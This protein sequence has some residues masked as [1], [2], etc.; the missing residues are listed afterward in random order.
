MENE[1]GVVERKAGLTQSRETTLEL[2][3]ALFLGK[4]RDKEALRVD[5]DGARGPEGMTWHIMLRACMHV[6]LK[7]NSIGWG[8]L[9]RYPIV[10]E[11]VLRTEKMQHDREVSADDTS[12]TVGT[13]LNNGK[14]VTQLWN[15]PPPGHTI[16]TYNI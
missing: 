15:P 2:K 10:D 1:K 8:L 13:P 5:Q 14:S 7:I 16:H 12:R 11:Q 6:S 9:A 3:H 4:M